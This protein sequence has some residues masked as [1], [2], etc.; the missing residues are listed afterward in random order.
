[1]HPAQIQAALK[2]SCYTQADIARECGVSRPTVH[3]V[4]SGRGRSR[5]IERRIAAVTGLPLARLWPDWHGP[6]AEQVR[7]RRMSGPAIDAALRA[8]G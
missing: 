2:M 5:Q 7:R 3:A 1:M 8:L 6:Q 4:I